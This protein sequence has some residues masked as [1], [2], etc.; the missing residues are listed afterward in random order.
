V[1]EWETT[2]RDGS[3]AVLRPIREDDREGIRRGFEEMSE[4]SR[5]RRFFS[6]APQLTPAQLTY[7]TDVDHHD[8]EAVVAESPDGTPM[9]VARY[10]RV[11][12]ESSTAEVAV[13][14]V[15]RHQGKGV[16]SA[17][18]DRLADRAR[19]E[20]VERFTAT[21]L[22]TNDDVIDL[23]ARMGPTS[24][25]PAQGG[26]VEMEIELPVEA[27]PESPLRRLLR[28][29]AGGLMSVRPR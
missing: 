14:V 9:G 11:D 3:R 5:Y 25:A 28:T 2:L 23:L 7:L 18:L 20:G 27:H 16:A 4:D 21:A 13:A 24:T 19:E 8:H 12:P 6:P 17:L 22:A 15:D 26:V 10:V 29:A 1:T